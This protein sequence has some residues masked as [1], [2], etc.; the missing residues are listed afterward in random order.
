MIFKLISH[1]IRSVKYIF[2]IGIL[3]LVILNIKQ[4]YNVY[5][6]ARIKFNTAKEFY[7]VLKTPEGRKQMI[8]QLIRGSSPVPADI[9]GEKTSS[10]IDI[11]T[12]KERVSLSFRTTTDSINYSCEVAN[13]PEKQRLGL[14]YREDLS[15][16]ECLL[17][18]YREPVRNPFWMKNMLIDLDII[19]ADRNGVITQIFKNVK[20]CKD[21]D[22]TQTNCP[23]IIPENF[24]SYAV[25]VKAGGTKEN[26][27][28]VGD[29]I[30]INEE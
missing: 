21:I 7:A 18:P 27:I 9:L 6:I 1:A 14:M 10:K 23:L 22:R 3:V 5:S 13:T 12:T 29:R 8:T 20:K 2:I 26:G 30:I 11:F 15:L 28:K 16:Y 4:I 19:F 25:E 24:Y 17:F